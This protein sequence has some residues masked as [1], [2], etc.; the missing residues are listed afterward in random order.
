MQSSMRVGDDAS[1]LP[2]VLAHYHLTAPSIEENLSGAPVVFRNFPAGSEKDGVFHCT[3][4]PFNLQQA[5]VV[6]PR[7]VGLKARS[8]TEAQQLLREAKHPTHRC[9][10]RHYL[11]AQS[12]FY[13]P[14]RLHSMQGPSRRNHGRALTRC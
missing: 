10:A 7:Q 4:I 14:S 12:V 9:T 5:A 8:E 1:V 11:T 6:R 13:P 2:R 3:S